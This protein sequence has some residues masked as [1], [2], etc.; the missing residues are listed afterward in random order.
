MVEVE[1]L[2]KHPADTTA[3]A[4]GDVVLLSAVVPHEFR[5]SQAVITRTDTSHCTVCVLDE[6]GR[7]GVGECWP[8]F[9]DVK[10]VSATLRLGNRVVVDGCSGPQTRWLNGHAGTIVSHRREGHPCF[11]R[12]K[13]HLSRP[14]QFNV[15]IC[16][17][18]PPSPSE[19]L[20]LIEPRFLSEYD[21][22]TEEAT[23][24][25]GAVVRRVSRNSLGSSACTLTFTP[26][27]LAA[28]PDSDLPSAFSP[29]DSATPMAAAVVP[30]VDGPAIFTRQRSTSLPQPRKCRST[31]EPEL[32]TCATAASDPTAAEGTCARNASPCSDAAVPA[33]A[34][35][36]SCGV[37]PSVPS[38][39][40]VLGSCCGVDALLLALLWTLDVVIS[41]I[42]G[43]GFVGAVWYN[44]ACCLPVCSLYI[45]AA[46]VALMSPSVVRCFCEPCRKSLPDTQPRR[47]AEV[48]KAAFG[49]LCGLY[50][51]YCLLTFSCAALAYGFGCC[52]G[53]SY[54]LCAGIGYGLLPAA[55]DGMQDTFVADKEIG[56]NKLLVG[57][58]T[59][60]G[61]ANWENTSTLAGLCLGSSVALCAVAMRAAQLH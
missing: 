9:A 40:N 2:A 31:Q 35:S 38:T 25:L 3:C 14:P 45:K 52:P 54:W 36:P 18:Q 28:V 12:S 51:V 53:V 55:R 17:E 30:G 13:R 16:L 8:S 11:V 6:T 33:A 43:P 48:C 15:C 10:L 49:G 29:L 50:E 39:R 20:V 58:R 41:L 26:R 7:F 19:R 24:R 57:V 44:V 21:Q 60:A 56:W 27:C 4:V 37:A 23:Y 61:P 32:P 5:N 59:F 47:R 1:L 46:A 42:C 22:F 34:V